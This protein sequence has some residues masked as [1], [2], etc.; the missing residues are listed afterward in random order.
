MGEEAGTP[1]VNLLTATKILTHRKVM[2]PCWLKYSTSHA[3]ISEGREFSQMAVGVLVMTSKGYGKVV[4]DPGDVFRQ[5]ARGGK[6][7]TG[8]KVTDDSGPVV[9]VL[10]VPLEADPPERVL[11]LTAQGQAILTLVD[12]IAKRSRTAGGVRIISLADGDEV[13]GVTV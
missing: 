13:V 11:V 2:A 4:E 3:K 1:I 9:A 6:G 5:Q 10:R 12:E 8:Y 7:V